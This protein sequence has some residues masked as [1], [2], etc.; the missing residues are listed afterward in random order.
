[1][2]SLEPLR[3]VVR[4]LADTFKPVRLPRNGHV[5]LKLFCVQY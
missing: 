3:E 5:K 4:K 1:M 2:S